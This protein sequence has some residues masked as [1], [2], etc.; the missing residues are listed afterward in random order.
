LDARYRQD[1]ENLEKAI[2]QKISERISALENTLAEQSASIAVLRKGAE[3]ADANLHRLIGSVERLC[4]AAQFARAQPAAEP[5]PA[6]AGSMEGVLF[7]RQ[8]TQALRHPVSTVPGSPRP[9]PQFVKET[10]PEERKPRIPMTRIFGMLLTF[11][12]SRFF[13]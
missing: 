1:L 13:R 11:G 4:E 12:L 2:D 8:L 6:P 7:H 3:A 10:A 9:Q 5:A